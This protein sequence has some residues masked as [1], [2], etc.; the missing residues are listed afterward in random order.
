MSA[1][2]TDHPFSVPRYPSGQ[3]S[4]AAHEHLLVTQGTGQNDC[5]A[6]A[7]EQGQA[8]LSHLALPDF[9]NLAALHLALSARLKGARVGLRLDLRGDEAFVWPL[10]ALARAAGL[11]VDEILLRCS[12]EGIRRVFC[13][14]CATCQS[15]AAVTT[16]TCVHCGVVL[17]VRRHFSQRLG[18]YLGVCADADQPYQEVSS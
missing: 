15:A 11:Q 7:A 4:L 8:R 10:H 3:P 5:A 2:A 12:P 18:A 13:V 14:H 1:T 17:E 9:A 6:L 16:L